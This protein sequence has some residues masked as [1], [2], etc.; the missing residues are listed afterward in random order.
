ML[1]RIEQLIH[2]GTKKGTAWLRKWESQIA[3]ALLHGQYRITPEGVV[4]FED[5]LLRGE[6]HHRNPWRESDFIVDHNLIVDQGILKAL[7]VNF[8]TD[9]KISTWYLALLSGSTTPLASHTAANFA[10]ALGEITSTTEGYSGSVRKTWVSAA[11]AANVV[12]NLAAKATFNI[13]ATTTVTATGGALVSTDARGGTTGVL[14]SAALW[15]LPRELV[16]GEP[17]ELGYQTSLVSG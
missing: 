12:S 6:F 7:A 11:P 3:S 15:S 14:W 16:G 9:A 4:L 8:F 1:S 10:T 17:F 2:T 5:R 13:V